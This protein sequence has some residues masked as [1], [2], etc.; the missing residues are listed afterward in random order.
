MKIQRYMDDAITYYNTGKY[1]ISALMLLI[2][3]NL[4]LK[5][6]QVFFIVISIQIN[7]IQ[8]AGADKSDL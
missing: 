6:H 4:K 5:S 2:V 1:S 8:I 7:V 3:L